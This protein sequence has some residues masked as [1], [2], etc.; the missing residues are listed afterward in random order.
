MKVATAGTGAALALPHD[1]A[2]GADS[3]YP[4]LAQLKL[5]R[6]KN[7]IISPDKTYRM[8]EWSLHFPPEAKFDFD[9]DAA[10]KETRDLGTESVMSYAQDNW[11]YAHYPSDIGVRHPNMTDDFFGRQVELTRQYGMSVVAYYCFQ[12]NTQ[13]V[14]KHPDWCC[15]NE[16]GEPIHGRW[17][18]PC[19]D[20]PYRQYTLGMIGEICQ[21]YD[22]DE[23]FI[24]IF[25]IQFVRFF[26]S[27]DSPFCFC[28]YTEDAWNREYRGDSYREGFKTREGWEKRYRWHR[29]RAMI[30]MLDEVIAEARKHRPKIIIALN[31]GPE[32]FPDEVQRRVDFLYSEPVPS[33]TG[34]A[35]GS[36][37]LRGWGR[38]DYQ[39]GI[40]TMW[41]YVDSLPET[42]FRTQCDALLVQNSRVFFVGESPIVPGDDSKLNLAA[43]WYDRNRQ[44]F[45]DVRNV[46]CLLSGAQ[47]VLSSAVLYSQPTIEEMAVQ[48]RP[49][50]F[51][52]S[53]L[54]AIETLTYAGRPVESLPEF[55]FA[56]QLPRLDT[57]VLPEVECLSDVHAAH[58]TEWV[59]N[60]GTLLATHRCGLKDEKQQARSNFPLAAVLGVDFAREERKYAFNDEGEPRTSAATIYLES[61]GH[62]LAAIWGKKTVGLPG[63]FVC[64]KPTTA[65][66]VMQ[67]RLPLMI[68][69]V[70]HNQFFNFGPWPPAEGSAGPAVTL[71]RFGKGQAIYIGAPIFRAMKDRPYWIRQWIPFLLR[72]LVPRPI[73]ELKLEPFSE[74]AHGSFFYDKSGRF[75]IVQVVNTS[76]LAMGGELREGPSAT[77]VVDSKKLKIEGARMVWPRTTDL[78]L[79]AQDG[80]IQIELSKLERYC[81]VLLKLA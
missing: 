9:L 77:I 58:I 70:P 79:R 51:R 65:E 12:G 11:G 19:M 63:S 8:M 76:E 20:S 24:D 10:M 22:I 28:K 39:A 55:R 60:G 49:L 47:P 35:M 64:V 80:R 69:D 17:F 38:P 15:L 45:A 16:R 21:R 75:V 1:Y 42:T 53:V 14:Q 4:D 46:D 72:Q 29:Q 71:N 41:P 6:Q 43:R 32:I 59:R 13:I 73:V 18:T 48:K 30:G 52:H 54:G 37:I 50:D 62:P 36:I 66:T 78:S 74:Y 56:S 57:L 67:Y 61:S 40:F 5:A 2:S 23:L 81:M 26:N 7:G 25:A 34:I 33:V 68:E 44:G 31:G 27:G 3:G